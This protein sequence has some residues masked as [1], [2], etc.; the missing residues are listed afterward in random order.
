MPKMHEWQKVYQDNN[1]YRAEIVRSVLEENE[2]NPVLLSKRD[3]A[4][5]LGHFEILVA[6]DQVMM[7]IK[8][9][10]DKIQFE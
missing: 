3:S 1:H 8:I 2:M 4:Y 5:Q 9:I 7:A 10:N 6:P